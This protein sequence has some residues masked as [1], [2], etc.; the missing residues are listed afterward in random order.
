[1]RNYV[2]IFLKRI[3]GVQILGRSLRT[4]LLLVSRSDE[5]VKEFEL[6]YI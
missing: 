1:M 3:D 2:Q 4:E 5:L 6:Q